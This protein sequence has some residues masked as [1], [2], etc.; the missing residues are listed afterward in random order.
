MLI[1]LLVPLTAAALMRPSAMLMHGHASTS[2]VSPMMSSDNWD[3]DLQRELRERIRDSAGNSAQLGPPTEVLRGRPTAWVLIFNAGRNDE[4]VYT[5]QGRST[6]ISSY[7]LAF[8]ET[9][10]ALRFAHLLQAEGFDLPQPMQWHAEQLRTF[11]ESGQFELGMVPTGALLTPPTHNEYDE[12]A[13]ERLNEGPSTMTPEH[14]D[15]LQKRLD[16]IFDDSDF[17]GPGP[18]GI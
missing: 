4:G 13:Y 12:D 18:F 17:P 10:E 6:P 9:D 7:V 14:L 2:V 15:M 8:E 16:R 11:C 1:T 3:N 5:L